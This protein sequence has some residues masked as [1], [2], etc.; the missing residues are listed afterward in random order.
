M[1]AIMQLPKTLKLK[2]EWFG[3]VP[4]LRDISCGNIA[5]GKEKSRLGYALVLSSVFIFS[6]H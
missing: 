5:S 6:D 2:N 3:F 4:F 1:P